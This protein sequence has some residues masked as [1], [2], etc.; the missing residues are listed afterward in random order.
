MNRN[1]AEL[2]DPDRP[3][4]IDLAAAVLEWKQSGRPLN[5]ERLAR[6]AH[7]RWATAHEYLVRYG[8]IGISEVERAR[9]LAEL[10]ARDAESRAG[11]AQAAKRARLT[12][13]E[14][15]QVSSRKGL[16]DD[17]EIK[18]R[19][20]AIRAAKVEWVRENGLDKRWSKQLRSLPLD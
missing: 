8:L 11:I 13:E 1:R 9:V 4:D 19:A 20:E 14:H 15:G 3:R 6:T 7:V 10:V 18:R 2:V 16:T 5:I 12:P 17:A